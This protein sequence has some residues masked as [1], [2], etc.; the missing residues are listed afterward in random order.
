LLD[1]AGLTAQAQELRSRAADTISEIAGMITD[2]G[3][4]A[5][6]LRSHALRVG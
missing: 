5:F 4:R 2:D 6:F 3:L 1:A